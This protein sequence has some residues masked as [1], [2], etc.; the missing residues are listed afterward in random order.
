MADSPGA[1]VWIGRGVF[2][3]LCLLIIFFQLMPLDGRPE[4]LPWPDVLL[5]MTLAWVARRPDYAPLIVIAVVFLLTD[6]LFQRPPGLWAALVLILSEFIRSRAALFRKNSVMLEWLTV[7]G[8]I[9]AITLCYRVALLVAL[10]PPP[11]LGLSLLQLI[12]TIIFYPI[13]LII[14]HYVFRVSRPAQGAV[15]SFGHRL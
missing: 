5:L 10:T 3:L 6:L 7:A 14:A 9:I 1:Q 4:I 13:I 15:D 2:S 12:I 8:G 11:P